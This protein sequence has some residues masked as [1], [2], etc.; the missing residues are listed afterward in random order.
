M[1]KV[2]SREATVTGKLTKIRSAM[3]ILGD[4]TDSPSSSISCSSSELCEISSSHG[5]E[6]EV[7]NCLLGCT[8]VQNNC[9][10]SFYTAV[11]DR[12]QFGTSHN[13]VFWGR[14]F[15]HRF[16]NLYIFDL[17]ASLILRPGPNGLF[18]RR[19]PPPPEGPAGGT[20]FK[21]QSGLK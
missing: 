16:W 10:Q 4:T 5:G 14:W 20:D 1:L 17:E 18:C 9:R 19:P 6:Y 21:K 2:R 11:Q 12:R 15:H 7:Q 3:V 8:A 13:S